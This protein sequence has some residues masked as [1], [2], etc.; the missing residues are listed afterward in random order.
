M[1]V[2]VVVA[3]FVAGIVF[4]RQWVQTSSQQRSPAITST[5]DQVGA[6]SKAEQDPAPHQPAAPKAEHDPAPQPKQPLR[7]EKITEGMRTIEAAWRV[8]IYAE[9]LLAVKTGACYGARLFVV[10]LKCAPTWHK[11]MVLRTSTSEL[12]ESLA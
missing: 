12:Y 1:S 5:L 2:P 8:A 11:W 10:A 3:A 7:Q 4:E 6:A 9:H